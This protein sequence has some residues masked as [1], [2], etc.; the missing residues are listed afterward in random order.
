MEDPACEHAEAE[1]RKAL[2]AANFEPDP[3]DARWDEF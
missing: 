2:E 1:G 3:Y